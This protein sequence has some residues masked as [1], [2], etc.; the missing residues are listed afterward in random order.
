MYDLLCKLRFIKD[1]NISYT[2]FLL[3]VATILYRG[4]S[5]VAITFCTGCRVYVSWALNCTKEEGYWDTTN[6]ICFC[7]IWL[8]IL[9][10]SCFMFYLTFFFKGG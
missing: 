1:N 9:F 7:G 2:G 4:C 3:L 6:F 10:F 8:A 5:I